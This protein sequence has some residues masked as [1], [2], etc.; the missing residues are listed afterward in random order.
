MTVPHCHEAWCQAL[1]ANPFDPF[2]PAASTADRGSSTA[3]LRR[4]R[5][6]RRLRSGA[7]CPTDWRAAPELPLQPG[8][9]VSPQPQ[10]PQ[11]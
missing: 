2:A 5:R 6:R 11:P 9:E 10:T 3:R 8:T 1:D 4:R 7:A